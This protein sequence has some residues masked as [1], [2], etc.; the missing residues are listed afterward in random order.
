MVKLGIL[1]VL[2]GLAQ[3]VCCYL[4]IQEVDMLARGGAL[5]PMEGLYGRQMTPEFGTALVSLFFPWIGLIAVHRVTG[6]CGSVLWLP[7]GLSALV[8]VITSLILV[9]V[10]FPAL[11]PATWR[12][13]G[14][15]LPFMATGGMLAVSMSKHRW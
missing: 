10:E 7:L 9:A 1:A 14:I 13:L 8:T 6:M 3:G 5:P 4:A 15:A 11:P 12:V 2:A